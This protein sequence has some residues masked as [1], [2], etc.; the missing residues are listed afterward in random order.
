MNKSLLEESKT[1]EQSPKPSI[2]Q[3]SFLTPSSLLRLFC[4]IEFPAAGR[5]R[6]MQHIDRLRELVP[7]AQASWGRESNL[8]L[9]IKFLG[10]VP[11]E[12]LANLAQAA[13]RA[14]AGLNPFSISLSQTGAFPKFGAPRVLWI[15]IDDPSS[16]LAELQLRLEEECAVEGFRKEPRPFHPHLTITRLRKPSGARELARVHMQMGFDPIEVLVSELVVMRSELSSK[17]SKHTRMSQ[18][19]FR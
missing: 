3:L 7:N 12:R 11:A 10:N 14:V 15:G 13:S 8:H 19:H 5:A 18:H 2:S 9:T 1:K 16:K 4:A 6:V 17:G